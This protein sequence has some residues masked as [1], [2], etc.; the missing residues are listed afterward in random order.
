MAE[1][2]SCADSRENA[3]SIIPATELYDA[4]TLINQTDAAYVLLAKFGSPS[5]GA[6][7]NVNSSL[8]RASAGGTLTMR[9]LLDVGEV[10]RVIR[11]LG[12]ALFAAGRAERARRIFCVAHAQ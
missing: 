4:Q 3:L 9:E 11:S 10:L 7:K 12:V 2:T 8:A 6:L 1:L 5:F